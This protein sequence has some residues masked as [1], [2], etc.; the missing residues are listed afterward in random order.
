MTTSIREQ[1]WV[2]RA[3]CR[4]RDALECL[5][6][7]V[8]PWL[9][10][11]L[12]GLVGARDAE[13]L[14]QEVLILVCRHL[15]CLRTPELFRPWVYRIASRAALRHLRKENRCPEMLPD[16]SVSLDEIPGPPLPV[17]DETL[18][19]LL[20][21]PGIPPGSRAVLVLHFRE[22]LSLPEV[23]AILG[24]PLGTVKSRLA[25]GLSALRR[26]LGAERSV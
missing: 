14:L 6:R 1:Q 5:L 25:A 10:R 20:Q 26:R 2:L 22:E 12:R 18:E 17:Q 4:D 21:A 19:M 7:S 13:D 15:A 8:Q 16:G 24:I 3:Q 23:A 9:H 11:Y